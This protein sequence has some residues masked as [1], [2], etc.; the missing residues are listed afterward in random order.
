MSFRINFRG[1]SR[2]M[3][4]EYLCPEHGRSAL[5]VE[6]DAG[7]DPPA[8][9]PCPHCGTTSEFVIS[10]VMGRVRQVEAIR[11]GWQKPERKTWLDTRE[12]GEGMDIDEWRAK[13]AAI[14]A[15]QRRKEVMELLS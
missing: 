13:R 3:I 11:G 15:E 2:T 4:A 8:A 12:L 1:A 7:G 6:R 5:D 10:R 9:A 14:R